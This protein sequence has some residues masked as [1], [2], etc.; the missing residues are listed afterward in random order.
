M[1]D[2]D[3]GRERE[4]GEKGRG[5]AG[6]ALRRGVD[7]GAGTAGGSTSAGSAL[8]EKDTRQRRRVPKDVHRVHVSAPMLANQETGTQY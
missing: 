3:G 4:R 1:V 2:R 5:R 8:H 7:P 6:E